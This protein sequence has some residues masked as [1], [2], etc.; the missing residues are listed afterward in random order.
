MPPSCSEWP[1]AV[2][3]LS[4]TGRLTLVRPE[5]APL[6]APAELVAAFLPYVRAQL[7]AGQRLQAITRH[8]LGLYAGRPGARAWRRVLSELAP[9]AGADEDVI[10]RAMAAAERGAEAQRA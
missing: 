10:L 5:A 6:P 2:A 4:L 8:V 3:S 9:R 7:A 1:T